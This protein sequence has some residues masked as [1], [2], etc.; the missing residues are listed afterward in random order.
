MIEALLPLGLAFI[1]FSLGIGLQPANFR[2]VLSTPRAIG[3]GLLMQVLG[4]PLLAFA[5]LKLFGIG[6]DMA[7][8]VM[9]LAAC[10]G[11]VSAGL[12]TLLAGGETAL[13]ISLTAITSLGVLLTLPLTVGFALGH[14][15][16]TE[17]L[18][19]M[20]IL[21]TGL[22]VFLMTM[23]PVSLGMLLRRGRPTFA[24]RLE[25]P[26]ARL[27]TGLFMLIVLTTFIAQRDVVMA[28]LP[29]LGPLLVL[30]NLL[31]MLSGFA[32]AARSGLARPGQIAVA[33]EC[34]LQNAALGIFVANTL[35]Q[36]PALAAPSVV[37]AFLMN[38][39]ALALVAASAKGWLA[40]SVSRP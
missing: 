26:L 20:P 17:S 4:L 33:M 5:L 30:L 24:R 8:G 12:L 32:A 23:L 27:S 6:G 14:F 38:F 11:G 22:G 40:S 28:H 35:L 29:S 15:T 25:T 18:L 10:P 9:I 19:P 7:V 13:S 39:S 3:I 2:R 21:R 36:T 16:G 1:M 34:G 31:T 37:Y